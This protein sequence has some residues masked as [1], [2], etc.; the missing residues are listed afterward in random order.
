VAGKTIAEKLLSATSGRDA[1]AGEIVVCEFDA[2][3]GTDGST[4]MAIDYFHEMGGEHVHDPS[5]IFFSLDHYSP[6]TSAA[7]AHL[8]DRMRA[9]AHEHGIEVFE[10]GEGI[11]LKLMVER[12]HCLPGTLVIGADSHA[13]MFGALNC[14]GTG[15]GSSDLAAA[16]I[17]GK[18]WLKAPESLRVFLDGELSPGVSPKDV[19]LELTRQLGGEGASY[20]ALEF[21]CDGIAALDLEDRIVISNMG[22]EM[23]AKAALFPAD[24]PTE[25]YLAARTKT[26]F[27]AVTP[28][29][30]A[31]YVREV[32][33]DLASLTPRIALPHL[34]DNVRSVEDAIG[35]EIQMV[36]IGT[37]MGGRT[38]DFHQA[39]RVI[40]AGGGVAPTVQLVITPASREVYLDLLRDGSLERFVSYGAVVTTPG[41]GA[42]C[43]TSGVIPGDGV[44]VISTANRN[45]KARM[46]NNTASIILASPAVC[47]AAAVAGC[48]TASQQGAD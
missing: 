48:I 47:A 1:R 8:H 3:L 28:D 19:V 30:D 38:R 21:A 15:I 10:V 20:L 26:K 12:G 46:G 18:V 13:V 32:R 37:C 41:C 45:F 6:P 7:S 29:I 9:F 24:A 34:P 44:N 4:P 35:T 25:R 11:G 17:S 31:H 14:F 23:G 43:G 33:I 42:C 5:R 2:A 16:M 36:F 27:S 22:T 40:E 39:L